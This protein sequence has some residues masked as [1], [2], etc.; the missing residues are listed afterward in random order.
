M[1]LYKKIISTLKKPLAKNFVYYSFGI[2]ASGILSF[3]FIPL[4]VRLYSPEIYGMYSIGFSTLSIVSMFCY[5]WVG[6][7]YIR[8][9]S[10]YYDK[11]NAIAIKLLSYA[12]IVGFILFSIL[13]FTVTKLDLTIFFLFIPTFFL[14]GYYSLFL[15][16]CQGK[17]KAST[18]ASSEFLRTLIIVVI[19]LLLFY[20]FKKENSLIVLSGSLILSYLIPLSLFSRQI[21]YGKNTSA[22]KGLSRAEVAKIKKIIFNFGLP[23]TFFLA[24]S[25]ALSVNDRF[26]IARLMGYKSAGNYS[27]IYDILYKTSMAVCSP[28]FMTTYPHISRQYNSGNKKGA[29]S[30]L[31]K[32]VLMVIGIFL[33][34]L[35]F[36]YFGMNLLLSMIF[37][38]NIP[39]GFTKISFILYAGVFLWCI[40]QLVHKPLE[41]QQKTKFMAIGVFIAFAFNFLSN[42]FLLRRYHDLLIPAYTTLAA[43]IL[44]IL[45]IVS[46][47]F[48]LGRKG[49]DAI[50]LPVPTE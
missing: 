32:A 39:P 28:I 33:A 26:I 8:F 7:S 13:F 16:V 19:P 30:S 18:F 35:I 6:Y 41:M 27:A 50:L 44:Y 43:S 45:F 25:A 38:N 11:L 23:I 2:I 15:L 12:L 40:G 10:L 48:F 17:Q 29:Y 14:A 46:C 47:L 4:V 49:A 9:Y 36:L 20:F 22:I 3:L 1:L 34:G 37:K 21:I 5:G 31:W 42:Y 24:L